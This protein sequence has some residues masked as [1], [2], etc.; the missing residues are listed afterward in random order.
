[1]NRKRGLI[2]I[3]L[4]LSIL[5]LVTQTGAFS[6][7]SAERNIEVSV[8]GDADAYL[9][10]EP[11]EGSQGDYARVV[12]GQLE[13]AFDETAGV[14][15]QGVNQN[16]IT[17][18]EDVFN[19]TNQG[20][21]RVAVSIDDGIDGTDYLIT[22][23]DKSYSLSSTEVFLDPGES[24]EIAVQIDTMNEEPLDESGDL[25]ITATATDGRDDD[26]RTPGEDP[27]VVL[28]NGPESTRMGIH[29][30]TITHDASENQT[31]SA[32]NLPELDSARY[33][34]TTLDQ[35]DFT[36][37]HDGS[38][39]LEVRQEVGAP[40]FPEISD[41][42]A[43]LTHFEVTPQEVDS[44]SFSDVRFEF[45]IDADLV[46]E[47]N[48]VR[49]HRYNDGW[50]ALETAHVMTRSDE[51]VFSAESPG[52]STF[53][54]TTTY[55]QPKTP[56]GPSVIDSIGTTHTDEGADGLRNF[57]VISH[58]D[59]TEAES[60]E[61]PVL[62]IWL[63]EVNIE[64]KA[65]SQGYDG[66]ALAPVYE[67]LIAELSGGEYDIRVE[68]RDGT[69]PTAP[70]V[71]KETTTVEVAD[72]DPKDTLDNDVD[73]FYEDIDMAYLAYEGYVYN[74]TY[75]RVTAG[76]FGDIAADVIN[77]EVESMVD[78]S[79]T[80]VGFDMAM[81]TVDQATRSPT[82]PLGIANTARKIG[83][84]AGGLFAGIQQEVIAIQL[85]ASSAETAELRE[86]LDRLATNTERLREARESDDRLRE[87]ELLQDR[88]QL[89]ED[90]YALVPA[91]T[92]AVHD[93]VVTTSAGVEDRYAYQSLR[94]SG[95]SLRALLW[96]DYAVTT[97]EL[98]GVPDT[99]AGTAPMPTQ[100]WERDDRTSVYDSMS[101][102]GDWTVY[103]VD[104]D[105]EQAE[106]GVVVRIQGDEVE[107]FDALLAHEQPFDVPEA[108]GERFS[109]PRTV[110]TTHALPTRSIDIDEPGDHYIVV[111][112]GDHT[113]EYR[114]VATTDRNLT[115]GELHYG[116]GVEM[117][118]ITRRDAPDLRPDVEVN[119]TV[120]PD[121]TELEETD[122]VVYA[123]N[124]TED[125]VVWDVWDA[126]TP[127]EELKYR[128]RVDR[129]EGFEGLSEWRSV[130]SNSQIRLD[131]ELTEGVNR[132]QVIVRNEESMQTVN[133]ADVVVSTFQPQ[134]Y[135]T[136]DG[137]PNSSSVYAH[138]V[139]DRRI[140]G[141]ELQYRDSGDEEWND[142]KVVEETTNLGELSFPETG[143]FDIRARSFTPAGEAGEWDENRL[144]YT[145][146][147]RISLD[148]APP[149]VRTTR[150]GPG[151]YERI[152]NK[153]PVEFAW[154]AS[155][156]QTP[157]EDLEY[158]V[159][160]GG[161]D[162][163]SWSTWHSV[164]Q[165]GTITEDFI[166]NEGDHEVYVEVRDDVGRVSE[167]STTF[168]VDRT[169]PDVDLTG[170][171]DAS[172]VGYY[173]QQ[174]QRVRTLEFEHSTANGNWS[175]L[176]TRTYRNSDETSGSTSLEPGA[177]E[178]RVRGI[179]YAGN[180][181]KW[182]T[183]TVTSHEPDHEE[184]ID[185]TTSNDSVD[186]TVSRGSNRVDVD[187]I[188]GEA[189]MSA[190]VTV[191]GVRHE[192]LSP[193]NLTDQ[194]NQTLA[195]DVPGELADDADGLELRVEGDGTVYLD[196]LR[197]FRDEPP[198]AVVDVNPAV[199]DVDENV[200]FE[201][202][203]SQYGDGQLESVEWTFPSGE[204]ATGTTVEH[205]FSAGGNKSVSVTVTDV[206]N[207]TR[208]DTV[209]TR[210][211]SLPTAA[212]DGPN[213][214]KTLS[215]VTFNGSA[216]IDPDGE[217]T[218]YQWFID[219][220]PWTPG[221]TFTGSFDDS[222]TYTVGLRVTD[223]DEGVDETSTN[224]TVLNRPPNA[225]AGVSDSVVEIGEQ[226]TFDGSDSVDRDGD[227]V[228]YE[229]DLT[230][231]GAIDE[232][233]ATIEA[234][235][236]D[237]GERTGTLRVTDDDGATNE[238]D[239]TFRVNAPPEATLEAD[240]PVLTF[241][242]LPL[243][244][245][246][247]HDPDGEIRTYE[248][249][250]DGGNFEQGEKTNSIA[251]DRAGEYQITIRVTDDDGA[252]DRTTTNVTIENRPP[253]VTASVSD[254]VVEIGEQL[255]LD[256]S[257]AVDPD[258]EIV[259]YE[260]DLT[261]DGSI[262]ETGETV[263][264]SFAEDGDMTATLRVTDD[265][266]ATNET[267]VTFRVNAPPESALETGDPVLT[268]EELQL[269]ATASDDPG[270]EIVNYEWRIDGGKFEQGD[271]T[272]PVSFDRSGEFQITLRV[273][274]DDGA[275]DR[276]TANVTIEN[277]QP[278]A[279][280]SASSDV[281]LVGET[282]EVNGT[283]STDP[284]G[285]IVSYEWD[286][287]GDGTT[288]ETGA[289]ATVS[290][291]EHGNK[292]ATLT[293]T[294]DSGASN[295]TTVDVYVNAPPQ[296]A[297]YT[298]TP[299]PTLDQIILDATS[300]TD[301]DGEI[302]EYEWTIDG[303]PPTAVDAVDDASGLDGST[304]SLTFGDS[305]NY[306]VGVTVTDDQGATDTVRREIQ[307]E[308]RPPDVDAH[309]VDDVVIVGEEARFGGQ[310][311]T[312][313]DGTIV[314]YEWTVNG[315][316]VGESVSLDHVFEDASVHEVT[317]TVTDDDGA[318]AEASI[319]VDVRERPSASFDS[320]TELQT[321][322][323]FD[324]QSNASADSRG[325]VESRVWTIERYDEVDD[326]FVH[327]TTLEGEA[328]SFKTEQSGTYAVTHQ[329]V[330]DIGVK[331]T[332]KQ[333]VTVMNRPPAASVG[334]I[335]VNTTVP[336]EGTPIELR[337]NDSMD[338]DGEIVSYEWYIDGERL[339]SNVT[340]SIVPNA[341]SMNVSLSV[342]DDDG[343]TNT[344]TERID[345]REAPSVTIDHDED[346]H[347]HESIEFKANATADSAAGPLSYEW[348]VNGAPLEGANTTANVLFHN[349]DEYEVTVIVTDDVDATAEATTTV[350]PA[351][352]ELNA[353]VTA[354]PS[355]VEVGEPVAFEADSDLD[356]VSYEW[357][358]TG[359][360][361]FVAGNVTEQYAFDST[362]TYTTSVR[363]TVGNT[364][365][366]VNTTVM[367]SETTSMEWETSLPDGEY[368]DG[369]LLNQIE[370]EN[371]SIIV[372]SSNDFRENDYAMHALD[373]ENGAELWAYEG[374]SRF[375]TSTTDER[376]VAATGD[377]LVVL[378]AETG[379]EQQTY[380]A[381]SR[382][383]D[384]W[385]TI[386][387]HESELAIARTS[388]ELF[389]VNIGSGEVTWSMQGENSPYLQT[390]AWTQDGD[391][392]RPIGLLIDGE[393]QFAVDMR[394]GETLWTRSG[395]SA[396][397][398]TPTYFDGEE[399]VVILGGTDGAEGV[400]I[401]SGET[402]WSTSEIGWVH[403]FTFRDGDIILQ[404]Q[405]LVGID[406]EA[407]ETLGSLEVEE[408]WISSHL[409]MSDDV[410]ATVSDYDGDETR[411]K[412]ID[413]QTGESEVIATLDT[414]NYELHHVDG[415]TFLVGSDIRGMQPD[416]TLTWSV[417]V[418]ENRF[419]NP[420]YAPGRITIQTSERVL[421]IDPK[422]GEQMAEHNPASAVL[423]AQYIDGDYLIRTEGG[424]IRTETPNST[425]AG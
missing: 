368:A 209:E 114:A 316:Q 305:G 137:D 191:R 56:T 65:L 359:D 286:F 295:E 187:L 244:A 275:T 354:T 258:G 14:S 158:R 346:V 101:Y 118:P 358:F 190:Y 339:N 215:T 341:G 312:D 403:A 333:H 100:G 263:E 160:V 392:L 37:D 318:T 269:D 233:G 28:P 16:A 11:H 171:D 254:S 356:H 308:N 196:S 235:F 92:D 44:E 407:N 71:D 210:V 184:S 80:D 18:F 376:L 173:V 245:S 161:D 278:N 236:D 406:T 24:A 150:W 225:T 129:G 82:N 153:S 59:L 116:E 83:T 277:R 90:I 425:N 126:E 176:T 414:P 301:P 382:I 201:L 207:R 334:V 94:G 317:L 223:G 395:M 22:I 378:N 243:D 273:T 182:S 287:T 220:S 281:V 256:G 38:V 98:T 366:T 152:T 327:V 20:T 204:T 139:P 133:N 52:F 143:H 299:A 117:E 72:I 212:I 264:T 272:K 165:S 237:A 122:G 384:F 91:Q 27:E 2:G 172:A 270:G 86:K 13:L 408:G 111:R 55:E 326:E 166:L 60:V 337:G 73:K 360:G 310:E 391:E 374:D 239:V 50:E 199:S 313:S 64:A 282:L 234:N 10:L 89:I 3:V 347:I 168:E 361:T 401:L 48:A 61:E 108:T 319:T 87:I 276:T 170:L 147:P 88:R 300:S 180:V 255:T 320:R 69:S 298:G 127:P 279:T 367:V 23:N 293:V 185:E 78:P 195:F 290:F 297:L 216:S 46:D 164:P 363:V 240:D 362:G 283:D 232:T 74:A 423:D 413:T 405:E 417:S 266:G 388:E 57:N 259:K 95:G 148:E 292:T 370:T 251:F 218:G 379:V 8:A 377:E 96:A 325:A 79:V 183:D 68:I 222:G 1:M 19:V 84:F 398:I 381:D 53:A 81:E 344:T 409:L 227:I 402:Q 399:K 314:A 205:A 7:V 140:G 76:E 355:T 4:T 30:M 213:E 115:E 302:V 58:I 246:G 21:Q 229:W 42:S 193:V 323:E 387:A 309:L 174:D 120:S 219:D 248:W 322:E 159:K 163:S 29:A 157:T 186:L 383:Y 284:D 424:V 231:D 167:R 131:L 45:T 206:F 47:P 238:T 104:V 343:T 202:D 422:T 155:S 396:D 352:R 102:P 124:E 350:T 36:V 336:V 141:L 136:T 342:T 265:D 412:Q 324:L 134:T 156:E 70:V 296:A 189:L 415:D 32:T 194:Q 268:F 192:V 211:N 5:L 135:L 113:G 397:E 198:E 411:V 329:V 62:K 179:D 145:G 123:T 51:Y 247:S 154:N 338:P 177:Y 262:D 288:D 304:P 15:G 43:T 208:E 93:Q 142:W 285:T 67:K 390:I 420:S 109:S 418:P 181:G 203:E 31:A 348:V 85:D 345:V 125:T 130:G 146:P 105:D 294:D 353:D 386:P 410:Y 375:R 132:V 394:T 49:L 307:V 169:A 214:T 226:I 63:G 328:P 242:E 357:D 315:E 369:E 121:P 33:T 151:A 349:T 267:D 400:S 351:D 331:E 66:E 373:A 421:A 371:R 393:S 9:A 221:E 75:R 230:G 380:T 35:L 149:R 25:I 280:A 257:N 389:A 271:A 224:V 306:T 54:V 228:E 404:G 99:L 321:L 289:S 6:S 200:V 372:A 385:G 340:A 419:L 335:N 291:D 311:S 138:V 365:E 260:W 144:E 416:G 12:D 103:R 175:S 77:D 34:G 197:T 330:D 178:I 106:Q 112:A 107:H 97:E 128:Y 303:D 332:E 40:A 249:R 364:T 253:T 241:E 261:D 217:I 250:V 39:D 119:E 110:F 162:L 17:G 274:D 188:D 41:S 26:V 252:T